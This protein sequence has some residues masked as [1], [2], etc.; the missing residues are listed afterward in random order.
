MKIAVTGTI[1]SGK[2]TFCKKLSG[3]LGFSMVSVDDIARG[4]YEDQEF[5]DRLT[6]EFGV[7]TRKQ[8]SDLVFSNP[9]ERKRLEAMAS[10]FMQPKIDEVHKI[11]NVII[12]FPLLFER[13]NIAK[14]MDLVI[15]VGC[16]NLIQEQR[17]L[18]R[19]KISLAKLQSI[20]EAQY[21]KELRASLSDF[22]LDTGLP[23]ADQDLACAQIVE[24]VRSLQLKQRA[25][26]FFNN[27]AIWDAIKTQYTEDHRQYHTL[28]H[29][30]EVFDSLAP[31]IDL[32]K[33]K[34]A[35]EL[36]V[37]FHDIV[38]IT[39]YNE[40]KNNEASSARM[41]VDLLN[42]H[43][44]EFLES[45]D[46]REQVYLAVEMIIASKNHK[47][48]SSWVTGDRAKLHSSQL[49]LDADMAILAASRTR[50]FEYDAQISKE[51]GF[52][53]GRESIA[54]ASARKNAL[55]KFKESQIFATKEFQHLEESAIS[56]LGLLIAGHVGHHQSPK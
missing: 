36:A 32:D 56:N 16:D 4:L 46:T 31:H 26:A 50:L 44:P 10:A 25:S 20:R 42:K 37:W 47:M 49:F 35:V 13:S 7:S 41:M 39:S 18:A 5:V 48:E 52:I 53:P 1:G 9:S 17:V 8:A 38:Y 6:A 30:H 11:N 29:L 19:D 14:R 34:V 54:F 22:Y 55:M 40:Y 3:L 2:T 28:Y 45:P 23:E 12:E 27:T 33:N 15:A 51:W 21:S 43:T 24:R